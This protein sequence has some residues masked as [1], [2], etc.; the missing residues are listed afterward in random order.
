MNPLNSDRQMK[1]LYKKTKE[2]LNVLLKK[3]K[4]K[5]LNNT[6]PKAQFNFIIQIWCTLDPCKFKIKLNKLTFKNSSLTYTYR[7]CSR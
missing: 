5:T 7:L 1:N 2:H 4:K 6:F 3:C